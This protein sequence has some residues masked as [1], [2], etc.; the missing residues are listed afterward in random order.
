M[1]E[2]SYDLH[3]HSCLSPCGDDDMTPA[4]IAGMAAVK[5]LDVIALT[6]HNSSRN[7]PALVKHAGNYGVLAIAGMELTTLEEVHVLA[8]FPAVENALDFDRF[9]YDR[10]IPFKNDPEV[11]GK[12]Q[13]Y[14][15]ND[16][17]VGTEPNLL[18]NATGISF[19][20]AFDAIDA[21]NGVMIPAHIDKSTTSMLS[22]LG[23]VPEGSKFKCVE[24]RRMSGWHRV[25]EEN[26]YLKSCNVITDSDAHYLCDINEPVNYLAVKSKTVDGVLQAL[27]PRWVR[28]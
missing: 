27:D 1:F 3:I 8:L 21:F 5:G 4:N 28:R 26:P 18:I 19:D 20:E 11:F 24:M 22:N 10:F 14:D 25:K 16:R 17:V 23:F 7:T 6:D 13:I 12:Q 2:I 15:E 9:V